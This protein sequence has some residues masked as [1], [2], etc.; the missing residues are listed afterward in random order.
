MKTWMRSLEQL[1]RTALLRACLTSQLELMGNGA[2]TSL[3]EAEQQERRADSKLDRLADEL[4]A[5]G[6]RF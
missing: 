4:R 5:L 6:I 1:D 2:A 3:L